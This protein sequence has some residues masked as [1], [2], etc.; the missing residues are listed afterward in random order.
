[1]NKSESKYFNTA[2]AMDEALMQLLLKKEFQFITVK[3]ICEKAGV[4]RS[5]FYLH[6]DSPKDI[7]EECMV[8]LNKRFKEQFENAGI[9]EN[10]KTIQML[11][12]KDLIFINDKY[13]RPYLNYIYENQFIYRAIYQFPDLFS[14]QKSFGILLNQLIYPIMERFDVKEEEREY[15]IEFYIKGISAIICKWVNNRCKESI[16]QIINIII[17]CFNF[18]NGAVNNRTE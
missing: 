4:N 7:L 3:E 12:K 16:D 10:F 9:K 6:Y 11:D 15:K 13:L 1:M 5:T 8:L 17:D 2:L 14:S 18:N